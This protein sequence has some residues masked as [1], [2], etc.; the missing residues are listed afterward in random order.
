M[1]PLSSGSLGRCS[2][3]PLTRAI[4]RAAILT[5]EDPGYDDARTVFLGGVDRR[6]ALIARPADA[7]DVARVVALARDSGAELAVR[8]GGHSPAGHSATD[9]GV[10]LDLRGL[11]ELEIDVAGRTAWAGAGLTAGEYTTAAG[12]HGLATGFGDAGSVGIG[13]ITLS[14]GVGF[15]VRKHGMTIDHLLAAEIVT[16]DGESCRS[17]P[18]GHPDLFWAIRGGGGN[19]GVV[20]RLRFR[21]H[22]VD[23]SSPAASSSCRRRPTS[24]AG[25]LAEAEAAPD[26]LSTIANVMG[27]P[28][29]PFLPPELHGRPIVLAMLAWTGDAA[30]GERALAP[31][32][33]LAEPLAD[34]LRPMP[35]PG[36]YQ[37]VDPDY[38]PVAAARTGLAR[39][40]TARAATSSTGSRPRPGAVVQLRVL[41]GAMARVPADATAFAHRDAR[42]IGNVAAMYS[43]PADGPEAEA[44]VAALGKRIYDG[45]GAYAGFLRDEGEARVR[46]AYPGAPTSGSPRSRPSTTP[47]T[48]SGSTRTWRRRR[49]PVHGRSALVDL[50]RDVDD[51]PRCPQGR[52][53]LGG[54]RRLAGQRRR[55]RTAEVGA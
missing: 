32:R 11:R 16:A 29:M 37:P 52:G 31:F 36:M 6:P 49:A 2:P 42:I 39:T 17:T 47:R 9:G 21:L 5:P 35:Y 3:S 4:S 10:V 14:G 22:D 30:A 40:S 51:S 23:A 1:V 48:C 25:F 44:Q 26:A 7:A 19:F 18:S 8:G 41:G 54:A 28:P 34:M 50:G 45:D 12:E 27:A 43:D 53:R 24:I 33:A 38:H 55:K 20:T 46:A 15:L 13:G